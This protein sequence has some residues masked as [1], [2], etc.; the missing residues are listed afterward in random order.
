VRATFHA[1]NYFVHDLHETNK[2]SLPEEVKLSAKFSGNGVSTMKEA[3]L[4]ADEKPSAKLSGKGIWTMNEL[5][6]PADKKASEIVCKSGPLTSNEARVPDE[7]IPS[8]MERV[9]PAPQEK[10]VK[11]PVEETSSENPGV[12]RNGFQNSQG[13]GMLLI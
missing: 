12:T 8:V 4:P 13:V 1:A 6:F 9:T 5:T 10:K 7:V 3:I 2:A 11:E